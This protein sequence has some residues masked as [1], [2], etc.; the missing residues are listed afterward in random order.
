MSSVRFSP[1]YR[2]LAETLREEIAQGVYKPGDA[3]PTEYRLIDEY[4]VSRIT[5][6]KVLDLLSAEGLIVRERGRGT[7]VAHPQ[8]EHGTTRMFWANNNGL[9]K[10]CNRRGRS[11]VTNSLKRHRFHR[12][13]LNLS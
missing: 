13:G 12:P 11:G 2:W 4:G 7:F 6:R 3:L 1:Y 9:K 10:S 8:L 5:V